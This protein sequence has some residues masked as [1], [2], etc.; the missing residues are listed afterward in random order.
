MNF[1]WSLH[2]I[3]VKNA[4][5][6]GNIE[7][8]FMELPPNFEREL[9]SG[10]VCRLIKSLYGLKQSPKAWFERFGKVMKKFG[11]SQ[12]QGDHTIF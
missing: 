11:Y 12:S 5:L 9:G 6:N 3:D 8:V 7:E 1:S 10:K 4:F 2:Q